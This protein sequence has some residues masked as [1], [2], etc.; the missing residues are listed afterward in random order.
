MFYAL[1]AIVACGTYCFIGT[2]FWP[3]YFPALKVHLWLGLALIVATIPAL[4]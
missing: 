1:C 4:A 3:L 2:I